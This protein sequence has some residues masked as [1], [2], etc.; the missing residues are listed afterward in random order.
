MAIVMIHD[1]AERNLAEHDRIIDELE[2]TGHGQPPGRLSHIAARKGT[3]YLVVDVWASQEDF[4]RFAQT[5]V[6][7][8]EQAGGSVPPPQIYP[9]HNAI[10]GE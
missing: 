2:A 8:I 5:L 4:D 1:V 6:P 9:L 3:G 10:A 7:F